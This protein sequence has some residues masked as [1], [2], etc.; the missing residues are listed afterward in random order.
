MSDW[1]AFSTSVLRALPADASWED[2][3]RAMRAAGKLWRRQHGGQ[4]RASRA[5]RRNPFGYGHWRMDGASPGI[6]QSTLM[7]A[8]GA[9]AVYWLVFR[10]TSHTWGAR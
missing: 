1:R 4:R 6:S 7:Y 8:L 9:A 5:L 3:S 10:G 2:R